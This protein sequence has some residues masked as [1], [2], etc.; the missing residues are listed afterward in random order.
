[1]YLKEKQSNGTENC[2]AFNVCPTCPI[3]KQEED[4]EVSVGSS[5][6]LEAV[7]TLT[8]GVSEDRN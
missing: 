6:P 5:V 4:Q 7:V 3:D 8:R 2:F 1:M